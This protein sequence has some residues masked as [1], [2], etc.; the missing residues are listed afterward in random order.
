MKNIILKTSVVI[1]CIVF[2]ASA[3][4]LD[5]D[6]NIFCLTTFLS[7]LYL[8]VFYMANK[9]KIEEWSERND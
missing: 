9:K 8:F 6:T 2:I 4:C 1:A 7:M 5:S 3:C